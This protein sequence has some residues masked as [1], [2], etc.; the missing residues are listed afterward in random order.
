MCDTDVSEN[1][2]HEPIMPAAEGDPEYPQGMQLATCPCFA[3]QDCVSGHS[4]FCASAGRVDNV[5]DATQLPSQE[6][7]ITTGASIGRGLND[8]NL[9]NDPN[10]IFA[11]S[12]SCFC[13]PSSSQ[14]TNPQASGGYARRS[15]ARG[16][17]CEGTS[18][19]TGGLDCRPDTSA[20]FRL[21]Q[22]VLGPEPKVT[23]HPG[24][25]GW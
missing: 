8:P 24:G 18:D 15:Q 11:D 23:L 20:R 5:V 7:V 9:V 19:C 6:Q 2:C 22:N 4:C 3:D 25:G 21:L 10:Q 13:V 12:G 16:C 14:C 17:P 1:C